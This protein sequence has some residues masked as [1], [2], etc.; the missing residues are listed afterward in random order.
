MN[1]VEKQGGSLGNGCGKHFLHMIVLSLVGLENYV[2]GVTF[3]LFWVD[4]SNAFCILSLGQVDDM[5]VM[6]KIQR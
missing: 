5:S 3:C 2:I 6:S 1:F 4:F